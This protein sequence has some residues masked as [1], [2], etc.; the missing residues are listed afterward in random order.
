MRTHAGVDHGHHHAGAGALRPGG[1]GT[2]AADRVAQ[3]PLLGQH[4]VIGLGQ[5]VQQAVGLGV[6]DVGVVGQQPGGHLAHLGMAHHPPEVEH[7]RPAGHALERLHLQ[8]MA[9][10]AQPHRH[11]G[12][13][14]ARGVHGRAVFD[15]QAVGV[16]Q[17]LMR[18]GLGTGG[19]V[20][21]PGSAQRDRAGHRERTETNAHRSLVVIEASWLLP[22]GN[23][24]AVAPNAR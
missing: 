13:G 23:P 21:Q 16:A 12:T 20:R 3:A 6:L 11:L 8:A 7:L 17:R 15:D 18:A 14:L 19:G 10:R 1:G 24:A 2:D 22:A 5:D 4:R 9:A